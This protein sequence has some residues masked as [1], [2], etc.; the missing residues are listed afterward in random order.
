MQ[1]FC[2]RLDD[3]GLGHAPKQANRHFQGIE[4]LGC[5]N[6]KLGGALLHKFATLCGISL[7]KCSLF[8]N[9]CIK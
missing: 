4:A 2:F 5:A 1:G 6:A 9:P 7:L 8:S 3:S